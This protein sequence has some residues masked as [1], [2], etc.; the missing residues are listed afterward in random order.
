[1]IL[2]GF[3]ASAR[4]GG[5]HI[6]ERRFSR[7]VDASLPCVLRSRLRQG[8]AA[9]LLLSLALF[10]KPIF[11]HCFNESDQIFVRFHAFG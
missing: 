7:F 6:G 3:S 4:A 5:G 8:W 10:A 11:D 1:M 2:A 9:L